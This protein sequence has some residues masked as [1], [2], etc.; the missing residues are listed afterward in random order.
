MITR[1]IKM[2]LKK[3]REMCE[4]SIRECDDCPFFKR[5]YGCFFSHGD[6]PEDWDFDMLKEEKE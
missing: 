1:S 5:E 4:N 3:I 6:L 2:A